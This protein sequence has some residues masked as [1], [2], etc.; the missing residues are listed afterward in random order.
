MVGRPT[1]V[2]QIRF[3]WKIEKGIIRQGMDMEEKLPFPI[4]SSITY[5]LY[6][7]IKS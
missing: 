5:K 2:R 1:L 7:D 6:V 4:M 3:S